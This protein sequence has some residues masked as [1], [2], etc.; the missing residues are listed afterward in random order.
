M[1]RAELPA[2][3][4]FFPAA[5]VYGALLVP[6]SVQALGGGGALIPGL[7]TAT[8]HARELLFGYAL[9]VVI[10]FLA[11]GL[12]GIHLWILFGAWLAARGTNLLLPGHLS[13]LAAD[14]LVV[15]LLAAEMLPRLLGSIRKW[16]NAALPA[17][18]AGLVLA[19]ASYHF[20]AGALRQ[21]VM[22]ETVLLY[23]LLLSFMGGRVIAPAVAGH[24]ERQ[25]STQGARVQPALEGA[26]ILCLGAALVLLAVPG[27]APAAGLA[28]TLAGALGL[29]RL[30]RWRLWR[31]RR[32]GDLAALGAGYAWVGLGLVLLGVAWTTGRPGTAMLHAL[33]VGGLGTLTVTVMARTR[34]VRARQD[35]ARPREIP[36][37][38]VMMTTAALL[39]LASQAWP[40]A[41][42]AL[43]WGAALAWSL[44]LLVLLRLLFTVPAR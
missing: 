29:I 21:T 25:G 35:P 10:G 17:V 15:G 1:R 23:G 16:R 44:A 8:D 37:A 9:A 4:L 27:T 19:A 5:A 12:R 38:A 13:A 43:H 2:Q 36:L 26:Q 34:L 22:L 7:A 39:R 30:W 41:G 32:R 11:T 20:T 28:A 31:V 18:L 6:V 33:T 14:L 40:A 3:G 24:M 42:P